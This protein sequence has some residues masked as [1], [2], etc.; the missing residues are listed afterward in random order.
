M[1]NNTFW[2]MVDFVNGN[3]RLTDSEI[4]EKMQKNFEITEDEAVKIYDSVHSYLN[5]FA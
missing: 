3:K 1:S 4:L 5:E 2:D